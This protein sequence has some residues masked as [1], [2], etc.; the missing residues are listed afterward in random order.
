MAASD[1][2][3]SRADSLMMKRRRSFVAG[4]PAATPPPAEDEDLP[5]LT[6]ILAPEAALAETPPDRQDDT[7]VSLQAADLAQAVQQRLA[8]ELPSLIEASL[9]LVEQEIRQGIA[10]TVD[11]ALKDF[12]ARRQQLRLPLG[13]S[14]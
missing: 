8:A 13:E 5:V 14:E 7:L 10:D 3:V 11:S 12:I 1:D 9:A 2:I 4:Q 6:E